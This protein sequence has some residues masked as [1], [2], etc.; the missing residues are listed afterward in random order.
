MKKGFVHEGMALEAQ[1]EAAKAVEPGKEALDDP[2]IGGKRPV[3]AWAI[4]EFTPEGCASQR[5][6]VTDAAS[7]QGQSKSLAIIAPVGGQPTGAAARAASSP[8]HFH[9]G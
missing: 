1:G 3:S 5:D 7:G 6:A 9:L 2:A 4:F 8:R